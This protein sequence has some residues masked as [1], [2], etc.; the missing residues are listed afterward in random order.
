M[1]CEVFRADEAA[2]LGAEEEDDVVVVGVLTLAV[3]PGRFEPKGSPRTLIVRPV[4]NG[5]RP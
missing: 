1:L 4:A 2:F 3:L 5:W